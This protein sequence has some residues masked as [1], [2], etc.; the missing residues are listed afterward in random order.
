MGPHT[1]PLVVSDG[2]DVARGGP[3]TCT[4][5]CS[6]DCTTAAE[7][8][9]LPASCEGGPWPRCGGGFA[10]LGYAVIGCEDEEASGGGNE[11]CRPSVVD[12]AAHKQQ[13]AREK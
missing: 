8:W 7:L 3:A 2:R 10:V 1:H 13:R 12:A 4:G 11:L 5:G 9:G 6:G